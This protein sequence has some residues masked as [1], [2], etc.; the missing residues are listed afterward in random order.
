LDANNVLVLVTAKQGSKDFIS[1]L[2]FNQAGKE[3][4]RK[5][6][7]PPDSVVGKFIYPLPDNGFIV[8][9]I[10]FS[11][12]DFQNKVWIARFSGNGG[13]LW[14]QTLHDK[15]GKSSAGVVLPDND[16]LL[17]RLDGL[18]VG[19]RGTQLSLFRVGKSGNVLWNK[20]ISGSEICSIS[21]LWVSDKGKILA[22]GTNCDTEK[23]RVWVGEVLDNG[24]INLLKKMVS[25]NGAEI[26]YGLP[27]DKK[28]VIV[29]EGKTDSG[30]PQAWLLVNSM[31]E[32]E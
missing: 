29:L 25:I 23:A 4:S 16:I 28:I 27:L 21:T 32:I 15:Q 20:K 1:V 30:A 24:E 9:G 22:A 19:L 12:P 10:R 2:K 31:R 18:G 8:S 11:P 7:S 6:I 5:D 14:D 13:L 26:V 3:I 17:A